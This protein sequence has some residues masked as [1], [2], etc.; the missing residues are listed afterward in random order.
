[1]RPALHEQSITDG[2]WTICQCQ[3]QQCAT[4][5]LMHVAPASASGGALHC[6]LTSAIC[7]CE[8]ADLQRQ[9]EVVEPV[10][11]HRHAQVAAAVLHDERKLGGRGVL[12]RQD[13]VALV[14]PVLVV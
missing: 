14:L 5:P 6:A 8:H 12:R 13:K 9:L 2:V 3:D 10:A 1:M 11:Q 7:F 4:G